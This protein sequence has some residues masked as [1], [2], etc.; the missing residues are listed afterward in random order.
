MKKFT[1]M[2]ILFVIAILVIIMGIGLAS[3]TKVLRKQTEAQRNAEIIM[4]KSAIEQYKLRWGIYP[5]TSSG[6]IDF[7]KQLS[8]ISSKVD[9]NGDGSV[10]DKDWEMRPLWLEQLNHDWTY[11]LDP[12]E[13]RYQIEVLGN[14]RYEIK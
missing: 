14:G 6:E 5:F 1:L 12:Y 8:P 4:I 13:E 10:D 11:I 2:E 9:M 7:A 3:G